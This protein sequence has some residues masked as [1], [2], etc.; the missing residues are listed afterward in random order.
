MEEEQEV[1]S[2]GASSAQNTGLSV[3]QTPSVPRV[4]LSPGLFLN[5]CWGERAEQ[6]TAV[7]SVS[8]SVEYLEK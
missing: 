7:L 6:Q 8:G 5:L 1:R 3:E 2:R 4:F